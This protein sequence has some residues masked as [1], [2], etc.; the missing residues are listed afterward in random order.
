MLLDGGGLIFGLPN[1]ELGQLHLV[2]YET[3][4]PDLSKSKQLFDGES[5]FLYKVFLCN[6]DKSEMQ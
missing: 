2:G 3:D 6:G 5:K 4:K 1:G